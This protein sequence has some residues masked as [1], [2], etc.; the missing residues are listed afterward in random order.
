MRLP[1]RSALWTF[2]SCSVLTYRSWQ[3]KLTARTT[4]VIV[5]GRMSVKSGICEGLSSHHFTAR[6][7][8]S[9][10]TLVRST[11][12]AP[13]GWRLPLLCLCVSLTWQKVR[14]R[15]KQRLGKLRWRDR[16]PLQ[17][18]GDRARPWLAD[19]S[20]FCA[21]NRVTDPPMLS[22]NGSVGVRALLEL[23]E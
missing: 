18:A 13:A 20:L 21:A 22:A 12:G 5:S 19:S 11:V 1:R 4:P 10:R 8:H 17:Q 15:R 23:F 7:N 6:S 2:R 9:K 16:R 3:L 14:R